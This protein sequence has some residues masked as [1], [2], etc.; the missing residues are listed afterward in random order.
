MAYFAVQDLKAKRAAVLTNVNSKYSIGLAEFFIKRFKKLGGQVLWEGKYLENAA[1]FKPLV[2][3]I[4]ILQPD[5]VFLPGHVSDSGLIIKQARKMGV[6]VL[7]LGGD[8][9]G[10]Q[11]YQYGGETIERN[12]YSTHWHGDV[13]IEKSR[14]FVKRY[15]KK[16]GAIRNDGIPL[17]YDAVMLLADAVKRANSSDPNRIR[18]ALS[19][20]TNFQGVTGSI[21]LDQYGDP[22]KDAVILKFGKESPIYVKTIKP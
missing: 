9:W 19:T 14:R 11:M 5:V 13:S 15:E 16:Y 22:I 6:S 18:D 10:E 1:D 3:E 4:K 17:C 12:Y 2:K 21:T 20:T 8:G 7:F